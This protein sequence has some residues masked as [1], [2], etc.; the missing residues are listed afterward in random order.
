MTIHVSETVVAPADVAWSYIGDFGGLKRWHP[1]VRTCEVQGEGI[2]ALRVVGLDGWHAIERLTHYDPAARELGY[3][4]VDCGNPLLIGVRGLMRISPLPDGS[5]QF[6]WFS[7]MPDNP[8]PELEPLLQGYYPARIEHLRQAL[9][10][11]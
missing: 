4:M 7:R 5:S 2:G 10:Q 3:E 8:P 11:R 9:A 6:D 1:N